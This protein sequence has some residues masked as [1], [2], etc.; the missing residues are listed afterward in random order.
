MASPNF[1]KLSV[2]FSSMISD[3]SSTAS[4][5]GKD[6]TSAQRD[7]YL[8]QA[9]SML[10]DILY[11]CW[12]TKTLAP[13]LIFQVFSDFLTFETGIIAGATETLTISQNNAIE[14]LEA[15][16]TAGEKLEIRRKADLPVMDAKGGVSAISRSIYPLAPAWS[17]AKVKPDI[18]IDLPVAICYLKYGAYSS[19]FYFLRAGGAVDIP[20]S[21]VFW[22]HI[23]DLA[24]AFVYL[25]DG[26]FERY[27][28]IVTSVI[29]SLTMKENRVSDIDFKRIVNQ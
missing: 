29:E 17:Q 15:F 28:R 23:K 13:D 16:G 25:H 10:W 2:E 22:E 9:S 6:Y 8:N 14:L 24:M 20:W 21:P 12:A 7:Y 3:Y 19:G 1:D 4:G 26:D 11:Q 5:N 18:D 27:D